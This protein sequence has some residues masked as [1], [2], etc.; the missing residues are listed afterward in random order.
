MNCDEEISLSVSD[1][2]ELSVCDGSDYNHLSA[3]CSEKSIK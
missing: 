1:S 2:N 3:W